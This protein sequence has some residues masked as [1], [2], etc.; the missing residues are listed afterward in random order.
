MILAA[1]GDCPGEEVTQAVITVP[2]YFTDA[3]RQATKTAGEIA[4]LEVLQII[5]AAAAL[6]YDVR[7]DE[8]EQVLVYDP[9]V[10]PLSRWL[11]SPEVTEVLASHGNNQLGR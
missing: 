5:N 9:G 11:R 1:G 2:A 10:A 7:S 8:T 3:Q 6:A 4:G